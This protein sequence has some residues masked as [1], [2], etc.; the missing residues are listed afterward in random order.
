MLTYAD[1]LESLDDIDALHLAEYQG[2]A[3]CLAGM[4][5]DADIC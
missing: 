4:L 2:N 1:V 5:T 3:E